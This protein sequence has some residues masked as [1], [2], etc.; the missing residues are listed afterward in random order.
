MCIVSPWN[1][2]WYSPW[3][4]RYTKNPA[5]HRLGSPKKFFHNTSSRSERQIQHTVQ[6]LQQTA[7]LQ[8]VILAPAW[9]KNYD[10]AGALQ[11][12]ATIGQKPSTEARSAVQVV[13]S[14]LPQ[15]L[16]ISAIPEA[17][18]QDLQATS[19]ALAKTREA[20]PKAAHTAS[21]E[22]VKAAHTSEEETPKTAHTASEAISR[23]DHSVNEELPKAAHTAS[24]EPPK[25]ADTASEGAPKALSEETPKAVDTAKSIAD[26]VHEEKAILPADHKADT[27]SPASVATL[28]D[29]ATPDVTMRSPAQPANATVSFGSHVSPVKEAGNA[30]QKESHSGTPSVTFQ[31]PQHVPRTPEQGTA[32]ASFISVPPTVQREASPSVNNQDP[33]KTLP[34]DYAARLKIAGITGTHVPKTV[35]GRIQTSG[36]R[37][38]I[39]D[40]F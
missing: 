34:G 27:V 16:S 36:I 26:P 21:E 24:T 25:A 22:T 37:V 10:S 29:S 30:D 35:P 4:Y 1:G 39:L 12:P 9:C 19:G 17:V 2:N 13:P 38:H 11:S 20:T 40:P 32:P 8:K 23:P 33:R 31:T 18:V 15:S 3:F 7:V 14:S 5:L 6:N 28:P